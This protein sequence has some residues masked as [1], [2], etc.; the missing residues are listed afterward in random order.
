MKTNEK[1]DLKIVEL[2]IDDFWDIYE[3]S[4]SITINNNY[5]VPKN[6]KQKL[7][8]L[9]RKFKKIKIVVFN[10]ILFFIFKIILKKLYIPQV[11]R[12]DQIQLNK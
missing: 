11:P 12:L 6:K 4:S 7:R 8:C 3:K 5:S 10:S 9:F 1:V 2:F